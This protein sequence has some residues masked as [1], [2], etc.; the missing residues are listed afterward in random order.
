MPRAYVTVNNGTHAV[1]FGSKP[2][3]ARLPREYVIVNNGVVTLR[4]SRPTV[5]E[6]PRV[7]TSGPRVER[8]ANDKPAGERGGQPTQQKGSD[9]ARAPSRHML[10]VMALMNNKLDCHQ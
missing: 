7:R 5:S 4:A 6:T 9:K 1:R 10:R 3:S 8:R 2:L